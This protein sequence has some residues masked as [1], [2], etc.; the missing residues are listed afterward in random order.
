MDPYWDKGRGAVGVQLGGRLGWVQHSI[1]S[2]LQ[3]S[4]T[5]LEIGVKPLNLNPVR[6]V[7]FSLVCSQVLPCLLSFG[8]VTLLCI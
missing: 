7:C 8:S 1:K 2:L 4:K 6:N 3:S 5:V